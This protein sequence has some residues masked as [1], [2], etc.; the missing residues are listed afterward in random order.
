MTVKNLDNLR[1]KNHKGLYKRGLSLSKEKHSLLCD[2]LEH[3]CYAV[4]DI[5]ALLEISQQQIVN[6]KYPQN[7][8]FI[9]IIV[10]V[11]WIQ[12]NIK[13]INTCLEEYATE[14]FSFDLKEIKDYM[15]ALRSF[16]VA[17]PF[18]TD[19]H[20][21]YGFDG[22]LR[23][24][25]IRLPNE[26]YFPILGREDKFFL[27]KDSKLVPW[28]N[29]KVDYWLFVYN[30]NKYKNKFKQYIG[31]DIDDIISVANIYIDYIYCLDK[32]LS[33]IKV[34]NESDKL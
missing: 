18:S 20:E 22:T 1:Q 8:K 9:C 3:I 24:A 31:I 13:I 14:G 23:C 21:E 10:Y 33:K 6:C 29:Q 16:T 15:R 27:S 19:R 30:E 25:D 34:K 17:H 32:H 11:S 5:N 26:Y 2:C 12:E 28:Q 7:V 4:K